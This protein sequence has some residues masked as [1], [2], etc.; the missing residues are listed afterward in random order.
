MKNIITMVGVFTEG[1][2]SVLSADILL[3]FLLLGSGAI[4]VIYLVIKALIMTK[5]IDNDIMR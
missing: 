2:V 3:F 1:R 5:F 4:I